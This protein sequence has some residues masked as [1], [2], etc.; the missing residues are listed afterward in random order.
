[1]YDVVLMC[2]IREEDQ[3]E[4]YKKKKDLSQNIV[5]LQAL[6]VTGELN[7]IVPAAAFCPKAFL[8]L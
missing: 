6:N 5:L 1:M 4:K 3:K 8:F 7:V 2:E